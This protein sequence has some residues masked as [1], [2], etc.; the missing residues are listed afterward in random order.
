[1]TAL[2]KE[3]DT[4][5]RGGNVLAYPVAASAVCFQ[6]AMAV[7]DAG[8][9]KPGVTA[10]GLVAVG[11]FEATVDNS[12]GAGGAMQAEVKEGTFRFANSADADEITQADVGADCYVVDDQTVAKTDATGTRSRAGK[13]VAVD[14]GEVWVALGLTN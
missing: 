9:V 1:M 3:R 2:L 4:K 10:T 14:N 6:G 8:Y 12:A 5:E 7:L 11:R 13:I